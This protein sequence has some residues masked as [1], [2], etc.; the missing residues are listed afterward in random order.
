[1]VADRRRQQPNARATVRNR[2]GHALRRLA[3]ASSASGGARRTGRGEAGRFRCTRARLRKYKRFH[4]DVSPGAGQDSARLFRYVGGGLE[5]QTAEFLRPAALWV[6]SAGRC[7]LAAG[8][9]L[10]GLKTGELEW[11]SAFFR[12]AFVHIQL[13]RR[14]TQKTWPRSYT[15]I[16]SVIATP[17]SA[18]ITA[19]PSI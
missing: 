18:N 12:T 6:A 5:R 4:R 3:P 19:S 1:M 10:C 14:H 9:V 13:Q 15:R 16:S 8:I 17:T 7:Q 2:D 11:N